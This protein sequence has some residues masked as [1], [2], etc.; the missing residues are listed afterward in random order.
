MRGHD[1]D[2]GGVFDRGGR[3]MGGRLEGR[4]GVGDLRGELRR[5]VGDMR[6]PGGE[7]GHRSEMDRDG[8]GDSERPKAPHPWDPTPKREPMRPLQAPKSLIQSAITKRGREGEDEGPEDEDEEQRRKKRG[9]DDDDEEGEEDGK[10]AVEEEKY[11]GMRMDD[12][13]ADFERSAKSRRISSEG[14][15]DRETDK[16]RESDRDREGARDRQLRSPRDQ[17]PAGKADNKERSEGA[18][19]LD[20]TEVKNR[21]KRMFGGLLG[22]LQ[23]A[24]KEEE[25]ISHSDTVKRRQELQEAAEKKAAEMS[26]KIREQSRAEQQAA[27]E[28]ARDERRKNITRIREIRTKQMEMLHQLALGVCVCVCVCV[29]KRVSVCVS[30]RMCESR[31]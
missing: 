1:R 26:A 15:R 31:L 8:R 21:N 11:S 2:G 20:K 10:D 7:I 27:R 19:G 24:K 29:C 17:R 30:Q 12:A 9:R 14:D 22:H 5:G 23:K 18:P 6:R 3:A 4:L 25:T 13:S 28:Q 16:R